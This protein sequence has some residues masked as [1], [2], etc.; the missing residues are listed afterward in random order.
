M[1]YRRFILLFQFVFRI[2]IFFSKKAKQRVDG[3]KQLI[4]PPKTKK[5]VWF[6]CAS[7]GEYEQC[8]P[9]IKKIKNN[10]DTE[11]C[12]SFFSA[13][14]VEYFHLKPEADFCFYLPFDTKKAMEK[15]LQTLEPDYVFWVKYDFWENI[16]QLLEQRNIPCDLIYADLKHIESKVFFIKNRILTLLP[17][18]HNVY[19]VTKPDSDNISY[20]IIEDGKWLQAVLNT[21]KKFKD[22]IIED[23]IQNDTAIIIGSA[24]LKDIK[25]LSSYLRR[26]NSNLYKW[27]VV[28]HDTDELTLRK[29]RQ[30]LTDSVLYS[31][32]SDND[33]NILIIDRKGILKYAYRYAELAWIGG[34]FGKSIH[35][36]LEA[37]AYS[38]PVICGPNTKGIPESDILVSH[39]LLYT[40]KSSEELKLLIARFGNGFDDENR[41]KTIRL[42]AQKS[43]GSDFKPILADINEQLFSSN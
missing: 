27:I 13:S 39:Q 35:N 15:L 31:S 12:I 41:N 40:F 26:N 23:F 29:A 20:R 43:S 14:G 11:V 17:K 3:L 25:Q 19:S 18:F 37:A 24:H 2:S 42:F 6:H 7:A 30:I 21:S 5:R 34:G 1:L 16:I 36:V 32:F 28:P 4:I 38:I 22:D 33:G 10:F 8:I 9:L